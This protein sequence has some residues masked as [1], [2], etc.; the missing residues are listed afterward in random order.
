MSLLLGLYTAFISD[1]CI[2]S[3]MGNNATLIM[4]GMSWP[5]GRDSLFIRNG[6]VLAIRA[7]HY[8]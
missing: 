4:K 8:I 7:G 3:I 6:N 5:F 2:F 1:M